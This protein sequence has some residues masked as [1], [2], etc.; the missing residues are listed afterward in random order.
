MRKVGGR[1][2]I[3]RSRIDTN[4]AI[5]TYAARTGLLS[6]ISQL[7]NLQETLLGFIEE[8]AETI[9]PG[10]THLQLAQPT[11][12]GQ[13][14]LGF[15]D[16]LTRDLERLWGAYDHNNLN[17]LGTAAG[18]GTTW[19]LSRGED[20][21]LLGFD[22]LMECSSDA[23]LN[24]DEKIEIAM[25]CTILMNNICRRAIDYYMWTTYEFNLVELDASFA[26]TSSIMPQKKNPYPFELASS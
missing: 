3:G 20:Y 6:I 14:V 9:M 1:L 7:L 13:Y 2:Q 18:A 5:R 4:R 23:C 25:V 21:E 10:Y 22:D 19:P 17:V 15:Y 8:H 24:H 11:S 12:Y 26:G 16:S